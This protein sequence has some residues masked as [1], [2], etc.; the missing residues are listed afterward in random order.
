MATAAPSNS[1]TMETVVDVG[2]PTEL[3]K[4]NKRMSVI[5]TAMKMIMISLNINSPGLKIPFLATSIIPLENMAP[6]AIP[7]LATIMI[8]LKEMAL[9]PMAEFKKF[10]ASLLTPTTKSAIAKM[11]RAIII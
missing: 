7:K 10:T 11:A 8:V 1:N 9:E 4:S 6:I 5:I 2:M 3:K